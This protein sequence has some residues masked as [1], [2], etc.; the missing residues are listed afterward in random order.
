MQFKI[1]TDS[2]V[3]VQLIERQHK[4]DFASLAH[5]AEQLEGSFT[6]TVLDKNNNL[7]FIKGDNPLCVYHYPNLGLYFYASLETLLVQALKVLPYDLGKAEK[8]NLLCGEIVRIDERGG[9]DKAVF[10]EEKLLVGYTCLGNWGS[11]HFGDRSGSLLDDEERLYIDEL[12]A[13]APSFGVSA[14]DID[15]WLEEGLFPED[16]EEL[17]YYG[18]I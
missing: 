6:F 13:T 2:F 11:W 10:N 18:A 15:A 5:M 3:V 7:Y 16:I 9:I 14:E 17:L 8:I 4:L 12:K 1:E